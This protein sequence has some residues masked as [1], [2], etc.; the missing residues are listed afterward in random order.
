M[1]YRQMPMDVYTSSK[2]I[3]CGI[4]D[5][6]TRIQSSQSTWHLRYLKDAHREQCFSINGSKLLSWSTSNARLYCIK[7][8]NLLTEFTPKATNILIHACGY[9]QDAK[10]VVVLIEADNPHYNLVDME[11]GA[12]LWTLHRKFGNRN[13]IQ[14]SPDGNY[15]A[16]DTG[17]TEVSILETLDFKREFKAD[18][19]TRDY[20]FKFSDDGAKF[21]II[22][23]A[24]D[25]HQFQLTAYE[26]VYW[27][28]FL[29]SYENISFENIH[30]VSMSSKA[31]FLGFEVKVYINGQRSIGIYKVRSN[32]VQCSTQHVV[33]LKDSPAYA[34]SP[35]G[36]S[37]A[38]HKNGHIII[39]NPTTDRSTRICDPAFHFYDTTVRMA[40]SPTGEYLVLNTRDGSALLM[41]VS[42][43]F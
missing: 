22:D 20:F 26:T 31:E 9:R 32:H 6:D 39:W 11:T 29:T 38:Y 24:E 8:G 35:S 3:E 43:G 37:I 23:R 5:K 15:I 16:M 25:S 42:D 41:R 12:A 14:F 4:C 17:H 13:R 1:N 30:N 10:A 36:Q 34:F 21:L 18:T 28:L 40:W 33:N 19:I 7:T 2:I 27:R